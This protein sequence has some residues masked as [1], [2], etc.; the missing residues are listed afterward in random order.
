M[1]VLDACLKLS[2]LYSNSKLDDGSF[3]ENT[4][5]DYWASVTHKQ[6]TINNNITNKIDIMLLDV[7]SLNGKTI[8]VK[9]YTSIMHND[10]YSNILI[11]SDF[12]EC[13]KFY[14][15]IEKT[16]T[17]TIVPL[18]DLS[19]EYIFQLSTTMCIP[20][21]DK[22][23]MI[24]KYHEDIRRLCYKNDLNFIININTD[25]DNLE[26]TEDLFK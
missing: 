25:W 10:K 20:E 23:R 16:K 13:I 24:L 6:A 15:D 12:T 17:S 11:V 8:P 19:D 1:N 18:N 4:Y 7:F 14:E 5:G 21:I 22:I 2:K 3:F 26:F 9:E